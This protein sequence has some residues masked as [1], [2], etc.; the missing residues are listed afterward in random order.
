MLTLVYFLIWGAFFFVMMWFG[1]GAHV[2]G[3]GHTRHGKDRNPDANLQA[4]LPSSA[5]S[6]TVTT[7]NMELGNEHKH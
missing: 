5:D 4:S 7:S 1:C 6:A 2:M 3:H